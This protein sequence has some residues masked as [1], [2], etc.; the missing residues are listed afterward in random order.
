MDCGNSDAAGLKMPVSLDVNVW[1][2]SEMLI[3]AWKVHFVGDSPHAF[4]DIGSPAAMK[5][6]SSAASANF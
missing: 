5:T 4:S 1:P 2:L 6:T 3:G